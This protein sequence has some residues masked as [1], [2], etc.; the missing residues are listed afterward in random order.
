MFFH[1]CRLNS[2]AVIASRQRVLV[3]SNRGRPRSFENAFPCNM[4][5][6][7]RLGELTHKKMPEEKLEGRLAEDHQHEAFQPPKGGTEAWL[8]VLAGFLVIAKAW[9]ITST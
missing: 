8:L 3:S 6:S 4:E 5:S 2:D 1:F 9:G 7:E